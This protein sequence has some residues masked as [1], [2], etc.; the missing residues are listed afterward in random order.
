MTQK[1]GSTVEIF[2]ILG[3]IR[4]SSQVLCVLNHLSGGL[5]PILLSDAGVDRV[6]SLVLVYGKSR[7][8]STTVTGVILFCVGSRHPELSY[9]T[10]SLRRSALNRKG[11]TGTQWT[12]R[13][14]VTRVLP[15]LPTDVAVTD[16]HTGATRETTEG[17]GPEATVTKPRQPAPVGPDGLPAT[18]LLTGL[19]TGVVLRARGSLVL[20]S[21]GPGAVVAVSHAPRARVPVTGRPTRQVQVAPHVAGPHVPLAGPCGRPRPV[22]P[23]SRTVRQVHGRRGARVHVGEAVARRVPGLRAVVE[24]VVSP[25]AR[26]LTPKAQPFLATSRNEG[27]PYRPTLPPMTTRCLRGS[28]ERRKGSIR[29]EVPSVS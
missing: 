3:K 29:I 28:Y 25:G 10:R 22:R 26:V 1:K 2:F 18:L 23:S 14:L 15:T 4:N 19:A 11:L 24:V 8:L 21:R 6:E 12:R 27:V 17:W 5:R 16:T 13:G 7:G 9:S 20:V